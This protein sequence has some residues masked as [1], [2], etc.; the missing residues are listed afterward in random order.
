MGDTRLPVIASDC[1]AALEAAGTVGPLGEI[2]GFKLDFKPR[3]LGRRG[4]NSHLQKAQMLRVGRPFFGKQEEHLQGS[5]DGSRCV[6]KNVRGTRKAASSG[7]DEPRRLQEGDN[8]AGP[9]ENACA[10]L[11]VEC[12]R[13]LPLRTSWQNSRLA[14]IHDA[15]HRAGR[16]F[17]PITG[18]FISL[19]LNDVP[20][21]PSNVARVISD[22]SRICS[23]T[24]AAMPRE[25]AKKYS[26]CIELEKCRSVPPVISTP[27]YLLGH[28]GGFA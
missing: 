21:A 13:R 11:H 5:V 14:S 26:E 23:G 15:K 16:G 20:F 25:T 9:V 10:V 3:V 8:L 19:H 4:A 2:L 27:Y 24:A 22:A 1:E 18:S 12:T 17:T 28:L 6:R 7:L